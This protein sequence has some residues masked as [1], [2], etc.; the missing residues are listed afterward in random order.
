[1]TRVHGDNNS[2]SYTNGSQTKPGT[3]NTG[4]IAEPVKNIE[5]TEQSSDSTNT[6][7]NTTNTQE[8][9]TKPQ[10]NILSSFIGPVLAY[11]DEG[12]NSCLNFK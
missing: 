3:T 11:A 4:S 6:Q 7:T 10:G 1:M 8:K 2:G 12:E 9:T 5:I